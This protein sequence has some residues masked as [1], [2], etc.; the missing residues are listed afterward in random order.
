MTIKKFEEIMVNQV[1]ACRN[2]DKS[3]E[4]TLGCIHG[5]VEIGRALGLQN[6]RGAWDKVFQEVCKAYKK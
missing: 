3:D 5:M 1:R 4:Y 6:D 2:Y